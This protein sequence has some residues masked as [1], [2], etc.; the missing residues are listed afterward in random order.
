M[1]QCI[2]QKECLGCFGFRV[3]EGISYKISQQNLG[4]SRDPG[5]IR[6]EDYLY[7]N[8]SCLETFRV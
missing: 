8:G 2:L 1:T 5:G 6:I 4:I 7:L 3:S